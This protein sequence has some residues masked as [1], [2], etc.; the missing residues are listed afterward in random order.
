VVLANT[1]CL[2]SC[3]KPQLLHKPCSHVLAACFKTRGWHWGRY[4]S[5]Y[6]LKQTIMDT[7]NHT[8]EGYLFISSFIEDPKG[9]ATYIPDPNP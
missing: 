9:N 1:T 4:V 5:R 8:L 2:C 7:W 6:Y 3:H